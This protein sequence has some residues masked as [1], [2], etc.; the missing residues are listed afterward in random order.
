MNPD[1]VGHSNERSQH[2]GIYEEIPFGVWMCDP[3][4]GLRYASDAF[5]ELLGMSM[6]KA[7]GFG[8]I[9][10]IAPDDT[11]S[12]ERWKECVEQGTDWDDEHRI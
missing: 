12:V 3:D 6:S 2:G 4:G 9:E 8:W 5:L 7:S 1:P 11:D 10:R